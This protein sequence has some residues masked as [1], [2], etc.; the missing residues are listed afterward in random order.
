MKSIKN[1]F[2]SLTIIFL[3]FAF[4][5][6]AAEKKS[7]SEDFFNIVTK[8]D[9]LNAKYTLKSGKKSSFGEIWLQRPLKMKV[10]PDNSSENLILVDGKELFDYDAD[11]D[12]VLVRPLKDL[13][14]HSP[15]NLLMGNKKDLTAQYNIELIKSDKQLAIFELT[16]KN[17]KSE[18]DNIKVT[19]IQGKPSEL[20]LIDT[21]NQTIKYKFEKIKINEKNI[22]EDTFK[23]TFSDDV[24][25]VRVGS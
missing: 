5:A 12:Q 6:F 21:A 16:P 22:P 24:D 15:I 23:L 10:K 17:S 1:F 11:L 18:V 14:K 8:I 7:S 25:I 19:F 9:N 4:N 3:A 20:V 13:P 2:I